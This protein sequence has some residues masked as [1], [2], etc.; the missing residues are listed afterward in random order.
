[1]AFVLIQQGRLDEAI[2]NLE[3]VHSNN[4][5]H[6]VAALGYAYGKAGKK[7]KALQV[8][9]ELDE[10]EKTEI[11]PPLEK[12]LVYMG[13]GENDLAFSQLE[14]CYQERHPGLAFLTT[15]PI[16]DDLRNDPRLANLA[17]RLNLTP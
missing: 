8:L 9:R 3:T 14:L 15:D 5:L 17:R 12:A 4:P 7:D 10:L 1:M 16:Y 2:S 6:A 11:V 13:L